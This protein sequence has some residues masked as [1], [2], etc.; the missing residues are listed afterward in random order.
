[1]KY[2]VNQYK[3]VHPGRVIL[4][5]LK[6]KNIS[7]AT[8]SKIVNTYPQ[9]ISAIICGQ[10]KMNTKLSLKIEKALGFPE[11]FLMILQVYYE[12]ETI[13]NKETKKSKTTKPKLRKSLFYDMNYEKIDWTRNRRAV[14][15]RV[16]E[17]GNKV[18]KIEIIRLYG[19]A[20]VDRASVKIRK[21]KRARIKVQ[22]S[23]RCTLDD[24][25]KKPK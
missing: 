11:G 19:Q 20:E 25:Y 15:N 3:G 21:S 22:K 7:Q 1:M 12:I 18:E 9:V 14:I 10:K 13:Q 2:T 23:T 17:R 6:E 24:N 4:E 16:L 8:L 5:G